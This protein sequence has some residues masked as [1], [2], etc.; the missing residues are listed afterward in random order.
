MVASC[1][2]ST[3]LKLCK[4]SPSYIV[5]VVQTRSDSPLPIHKLY[6]YYFVSGYFSALLSSFSVTVTI[7]LA[8][9][10]S[11]QG[12]ERKAR[13]DTNSLVR[14]FSVW[15]YD[16]QVL[17][18]LAFLPSLGKRGHKVHLLTHLTLSSDR[19]LSI[20]QHLDQSYTDFLLYSS[21]LPSLRPRLST[22]SIIKFR[23]VFLPTSR[24]LHQHVESASKY[25]IIKSLTYLRGF[26]G[27]ANTTT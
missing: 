11:T 9:Y 8:A 16:A 25:P 14:D 24:R 18:P 7:P 6:D 1:V 12:K 2:T 15:C 4:N 21:L 3:I 5:V 23:V 19:H 13:G 27:H 10:P 22:L 17:L 26:S 20:A